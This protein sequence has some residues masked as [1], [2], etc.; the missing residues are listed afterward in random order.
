ML[1][2]FGG[3][4]R[5]GVCHDNSNHGLDSTLG[6]DGDNALPALEHGVGGIGEEIDQNMDHLPASRGNVRTASFHIDLYRDGRIFM[7]REVRRDDAQR[8]VDQFFRR[9]PFFCFFPL[10]A[11]T[12]HGGDH[13]FH[14]QAVAGN[15]FQVSANRVAF[16]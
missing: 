13:A 14:A 1:G 8:F 3:D 12:Q 9:A 2:M 7:I 11:E 16:G 10:A 15:V 4:S 5:S 6:G